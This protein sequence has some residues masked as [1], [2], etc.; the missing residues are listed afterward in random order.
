MYGISLL[1]LPFKYQRP[2]DLNNRNSSCLSSGGCVSEIKVLAGLITSEDC[3]LGMCS[4]P[5]SL[6]WGWLSFPSVFTSPFLYMCLCLD[7]LFL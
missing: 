6:A 4:R 7:L 5:L 2:S 1:E 3:E